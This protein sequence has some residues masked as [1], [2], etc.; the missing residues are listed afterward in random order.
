[1]TR[2]GRIGERTLVHATGWI[3][4]VGLFLLPVFYLVLVSLRSETGFLGHPFAFPR[5][6]HFMNYVSA[7]EQASMTSYFLNSIIYAVGGTV[8][9]LLVSAFL[10]FPIARGYI[11]GAKVIYQVFVFSMFLPG[12][13][14]PLFVES[15][16]LHLYN[17]QLGYIILNVGTGLSVFFFVGYIKSIPKELDEA[18]AIDGCGY[19]RYVLRILLPLMSPA[20]ATMGLLSFIGE[21]NNLIGPIVFLPNPQYWPLTRGLFAFYGQ[22]S[23]NWP[24]LAAGLIITILPLTILFLFLQRY[25]V[26]GVTGGSLK[27]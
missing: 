9:S 14:I 20:L 23:N 7:W 21:W 26:A 10:A 5:M 24:L 15:Q 6:L 4:G 2:A 17:N 12:G 13:L 16:A 19:S 11:R 1:M 18:A 25:L 3:I 22:F 27:L 8:L